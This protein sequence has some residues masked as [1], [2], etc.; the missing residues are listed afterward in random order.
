MNFKVIFDGVFSSANIG[1]L[2]NDPKYF[3]YVLKELKKV[4]PDE[5][6]FWDD[7]QDNIDNARNVGIQAHFY[8]NFEDFKNKIH[9][10]FKVV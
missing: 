9:K 7:S 10:H 6:L 5:I 1:Y 2:K 3:R 8:K 4:Q